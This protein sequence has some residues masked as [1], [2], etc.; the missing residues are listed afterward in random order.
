MQSILFIFSQYLLYIVQILPYLISIK[1]LR[2]KLLLSYYRSINNRCRKIANY[3]YQ[4]IQIKQRDCYYIFI[5]RLSRLETYN[6]IAGLNRSE[7]IKVTGCFA[8]LQRRERSLRVCTFS[9]AS[10]QR[11]YKV[12]NISIK[13]KAYGFARA[14][15]YSAAANLGALSSLLSQLAPLDASSCS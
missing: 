13:V 12:I 15:K 8:A 11:S 9:I 3:S 4:D 10:R 5:R 14:V 6:N 1:R 7:D 2:G